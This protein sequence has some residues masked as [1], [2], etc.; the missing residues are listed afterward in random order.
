[1]SLIRYPDGLKYSLICFDRKTGM[2]V[3]M[4][5]HHLKGHHV[6]LDNSEASY[7]FY[8]IEGFVDDFKQ[9]VADHLGV[10]L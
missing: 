5:N 7:H 4:D 3:L 2:R 10:T 1:M 6:H 8:G 9:F